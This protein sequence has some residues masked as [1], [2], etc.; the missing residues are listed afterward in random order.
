[1]K[2][3]TRKIKGLRDLSIQKIPTLGPKARRHHIVR[4]LGFLKQDTR[5]LRGLAGSRQVTRGPFSGA[6][7]TRSFYLY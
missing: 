1:M 4:L 3:V 2:G 7:R 5:P 6:P